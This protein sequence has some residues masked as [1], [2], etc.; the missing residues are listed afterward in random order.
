MGDP[1]RRSHGGRGHGGR[2]RGRR[3]ADA[4][5]AV[6]R[7]RRSPRPR[8]RRCSPSTPPAVTSTPAPRHSGPGP[9]RAGSRA[10]ATIGRGCTRSSIRRCAATPPLSSPRSS[11]SCPRRAWWSP[12]PSPPSGGPRWTGASAG[13]AKRSTSPRCSGPRRCHGSSSTRGGR[14]TSTRWRASSRPCRSGRC[15]SAPAVSRQRM[16][17]D[18]GRRRPQCRRRADLCWSCRAAGR[19]SPPG[20]P[21]YWRRPGWSS[22]AT[23]PARWRPAKTSSSRDR[24]ARSAAPRRARSTPSRPRLVIVVGGDTAHALCTALGV[25]TLRAEREVAPG[26]PL[27][28]CTLADGRELRLVLKS[29]SFGDDDVLARIVTGA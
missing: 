9:W 15:S 27:L 26:A 23:Q 28:R 6:A 2:L 13:T 22:T 18:E 14:R 8:T 21:R 3:P 5:G 17:G 16:P 10:T 25:E 11:A 19:R 7:R 20:R 12:P 24:P 1:G 4:R 29:G